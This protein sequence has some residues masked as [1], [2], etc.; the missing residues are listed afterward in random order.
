MPIADKYFPDEP[1]APHMI[2]PCPGPASKAKLAE[3]STAFDTKAA[4]FIADFYNSL[5]NYIC[6]ADG[7]LLLDAYCQISSIALGYN[8]PELLKA[9]QTKEM[10]TALV[11]RPALA[12][13]PSSD[14]YEI[15]KEG[16]LSVAPE[17]LDRVC[18]AHTGSDANEMAFKA[19]LMYQATKKRAGKP[20]TQLE[21]DS[22]MKNETPGASDMVILSF[23][24]GFHGRLFGSLSTTHSKPIHKLDI[25]AFPWP[26]APFPT[27]KYPLEDHVEENKAEDERCLKE[28]DHVLSTFPHQIAAAIIEPV[29]SEGGDNHA[30][31]TF[32]QGV[33]ELTKKHGV[34]LIVDEVQCGGGGSGKMWLHQHYGIRPDLMTF[35]KK[36]QN[37]GFF[38]HDPLLAGDRPYRQFNTWCGD[39][40]KA[41]IA[42]AIIHEIKENDLLKGVN[43]TAEYLYGK[44]EEIREKY[45]K[46]VLN[47][48]GKGRGFFI[49]FD[50]PSAEIRDKFLWGCRQKGL[51]LGGCGDVGVRL[52]P[53]LTFGKKHVDILVG[54]VESELSEMSNH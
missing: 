38:Y 36:M 37:A 15:L 22:V 9:A 32:F 26:T 23:T 21:L 4:F 43:E 31:A 34:L 19:C 12:C 39:P 27:V 20:F 7:N 52:R 17:G 1:K 25:P 50:M 41:L 29:Q 14:Y 54:V 8:N 11:N 48:R 51:N 5:G 42:K 46:L 10:A 53:G 16:L 44:L 6:D 49:A 28:L 40:S 24:N 33:R 30:S 18:T 3:L 45:S 2:T 13:F 35:S 47:L